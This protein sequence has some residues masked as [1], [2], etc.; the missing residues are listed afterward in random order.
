MI[1][2]QIADM[3]DLKIELGNLDADYV[4]SVNLWSGNG[5]LL[6]NLYNQFPIQSN[7]KL[8]ISNLVYPPGI[9]ILQVELTNIESAE[10]S[11][12]KKS[13]TFN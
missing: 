11:N 10:K 1:V 13:I 8:T 3:Q 9:Y 12:F 7:E 4:L 6:E 5:L 2:P